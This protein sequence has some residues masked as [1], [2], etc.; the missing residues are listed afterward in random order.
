METFLIGVL[1]K[2]NG[3]T[4]DTAVELNDRSEGDEVGLVLALPEGFFVGGFA[5]VDGENRRG[6]GHGTAGSL[7][8]LERLV[9]TL[10]GFVKRADEI[11]ELLG[12]GVFMLLLDLIE[13]VFER[14]N[15]SFSS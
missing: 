10:D 4:H 3:E 2:K 6:V 8:E 11:R 15:G 7:V 14:V 13:F 12:R 9:G 1:N 5:V